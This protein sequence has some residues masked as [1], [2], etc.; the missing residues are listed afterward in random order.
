MNHSIVKFLFCVPLL[1][2]GQTA[3]N[4]HVDIFTVPSDSSVILFPLTKNFVLPSTIGVTVDSVLIQDYSYDRVSNSVTLSTIPVVPRITTIAIRYHYLPFR[5]KREYALRTITVKSDT[6]KSLRSM[7]AIATTDAGYSNLFG[8]ELSKSGSINRGFL[9]GTNNDFT[10]SSGFRLQ[11]IGKLSDEIDITAALTDENTPIQPQGNTQTL[12]EIDNVFVEITSPQYKATVGDF[13]YTQSGSEFFTVSRKLQG[14]RIQ[15]EYPDLFS[16]TQATVTGATARGKFNSLSIA[17]VE[18]VQGPYRLTGRNNERNIIIIAGSEKVYVDGTEMVRGEN[19]DYTIDYG[20]AE[21]TFTTRRMITGMSRIV[22]DYEYSDRQYTRNIV[23]IHSSTSLS[24]SFSIST[25]YFREGDD[26]DA[27]IDL[28]LTDDDKGLLRQTGNTTAIKSGVFDAGIDSNGIGK[29]NYRKID[30]LINAMPVSFYR[31]EPGTS[32][33]VY[34]VVFSVVGEKKGDYYREG[35]GRYTFVGIGSGNYSPVI[36]VP[37]PQLHQQY[38]LQTK[39]SIGKS[40]ILDGEFAASDADRNRFSDIGDDLNS[41]HAY[42]FRLRY[43]PENI[44]VAG[45]NFGSLDVSLTER[46]VD[47]RYT[48]V[49]RINDVEFGRKWSTDSLLLNAVASEETREGK[50]VYTPIEG[51]SIQTGAGTLER[52]NQFSSRRYDGG[53]DIVSGALPKVSYFAEFITG[54]EKSSDTYSEWFRQKG[55]AE[56]SFSTVIPSMRFEN[57]RRTVKETISDSLFSPSFGFISY[58]PKLMVTGIPRVELSTEFEWRLN[59]GYSSGAVMRQSSSFTQS[60]AFILRETYD[61]SVSTHFT[62]RSLRFEP[63]F[64]SENTNQQTTLMKIQSRYRPLSGGVDIDLFYD[65]ATQRTAALERVFYKVRKGEGQYVWNDANG[66]SIVDLSDENEFRPDRYDGEYNAIIINSDNFRPVINLKASSRIKIVPRQFLSGHRGVLGAIGNTVSSESFFRL[67]EKS[68][69]QNF[70]KIYLLDHRYFLHPTTTLYGLQFMQHDLFLFENKSAYS[71]RVRYNQKVGLSRYSSGTEKNYSR[72]RS[73]R[74]RFLVSNDLFNQTDIVWKDDNAITSSL[75]NQSR[76]IGTIAVITDISYKPET[77]IELGFKLETSQSTDRPG[78]L[79]VIADYNGQSFRIVY[80][81]RGN[82]QIRSDFSREEVVV[83][84]QPVNY[85][86]PYELTSGRET[87]KQFL[88]SIASEYR[89]TGNIQFS[90][91]Y[92]GR[93]TR[94]AGIIHT[95]R[96]EVRAFF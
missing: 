13:V 20:A 45:K 27:P 76:Q 79:P 10:V 3:S 86:I 7:T 42:K 46:F 12:Q 33:S 65:V 73:L 60:Y 68:T 67:E 35:I 53:I 81:F 39:Y 5:M 32:T 58:A 93:T 18:G 40:F 77:F 38:S 90:A 95:G 69:V 89:F 47:S 57:E 61:L 11:M 88:W 41:G 4:Y 78:A 82:G 94:S 62:L 9:I 17:G 23:G 59:D 2:F 37:A 71:F 29:G 30:T 44:V 48:P 87:G 55:F 15:A 36:V 50:I 92:N 1:I 72:E 75:L 91:Q 52:G 21:L 16:G 96:M 83:Q 54:D 24:N 51:V 25:N 19:N 49:D 56:Y 28:V 66:N 84:S 74:S 85:S 22:I 34:N 31:Y 6:A 8:P 26:P 80:G 64:Q 14:A 43:A 70:E 63:A